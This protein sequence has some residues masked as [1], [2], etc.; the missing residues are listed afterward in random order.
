[1][2]GLGRKVFAPGEV[3]TATNVQNYLM[4]QAVQVYAGTAARG[5]AI[6]SAITEGMVSYL[7]DLNQMDVYDGSAWKKVYPAA[8]LTGNIVQV[9]QTVKNDVFSTASTSFVDVTG[10]SVTITPKT[11]TNKVLVIA[12]VYMSQETSGD[13]LIKL[14]R[15]STTINATTTGLDTTIFGQ[16]GFSVS[17]QASVQMATFIDSPATTSATTYKLQVRSYSTGTTHVNRRPNGN[18]GSSSS[19]TVMEV[20]A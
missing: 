2:A 19:I 7:A 5:S 4:D 11:T 8:P 20:V 12:N 13:A 3:L 17:G 16:V 1:M 14:L 15:G 6:G 9:L 10:L 18:F